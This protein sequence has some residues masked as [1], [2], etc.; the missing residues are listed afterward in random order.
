[1]QSHFKMASHPATRTSKIQKLPTT[2][3]GT[4]NLHTLKPISIAIILAQKLRPRSAD[5]RFARETNM[6]R[7]T[8]NPD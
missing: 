1:L 7:L 8:L 3:A 5:K 6:T 2:C 4:A